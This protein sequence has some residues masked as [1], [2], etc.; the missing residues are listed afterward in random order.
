MGMR[1]A[2]ARGLG[3]PH[4]TQH[5]A[6]V[7]PN[8]LCVLQG[9]QIK[10]ENQE[11]GFA[12]VSGFC[13]GLVRAPHLPVRLARPAATWCECFRLFGLHHLDYV[14]LRRRGVC[15]SHLPL[16]VLVAEHSAGAESTRV[17]AICCGRQL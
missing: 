8:T 15:A 10:R 16:C 2:P 5:V 7:N 9:A 6:A 14:R 13:V 12:E 4:R 11:W 17:A 1:G 3:L